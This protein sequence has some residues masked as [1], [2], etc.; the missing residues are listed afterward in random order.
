MPLL[1]CTDIEGGEVILDGEPSTLTLREAI[2]IPREGSDPSW[3]IFDHGGRFVGLAGSFRGP[4]HQAHLTSPITPL[5]HDR[6]GD[7][8]PDARY[9]YGGPLHGHYG[10][11]LLSTL[12]RF[13]PFLDSKD[14]DIKILCHPMADLD[15]LFALPF[16]AE[17]F[18]A[19]GLR[20]ESFVCFDRP[21][22]I[23][24]LVV[25]GAAFEETGFAY[26]VFG[27]LCHRIGDRLT[28]GMP[29]SPGDAPVYMSKARL[30]S[31]VGR[32]VNEEEFSDRLSRAGFD[33]VHPERL[34]LGQQIRLYRDRPQ[35]AALTG[36]S[37][38]TSLFSAGRSIVG[39]SYVNTLYTSYS[40]IDL[41]GGG[42]G[43][44]V[45]PH[46]DIALLPRTRNFHLEYRLTDVAATAEQFIRLCERERRVREPGRNIA[47]G[48]ATRQSSYG[49]FEGLPPVDGRRPSAT[50]GRLTG[51]YQ[52]HT[53]HEEQPW[54]EVDLGCPCSVDAVTL[55][56]RADNSQARMALFTIQ[57]SSDGFAFEDI[58]RQ[59]QPAAFGNGLQDQQL[60][61][62]IAPA[63]TCRYLRVTLPGREFLHLD[64]V[65]IEGTRLPARPDDPGLIAASQTTETTRRPGWFG[66]FF[67]TPTEVR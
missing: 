38:H 41:L 9:V 56:N 13:W 48:C 26:R 20:R 44:Y 12:S 50:N 8:A 6:I 52:F 29:A 5:R 54:W 62:V 27:R 66:R 7:R 58:H 22:L 61:I 23:P 45:Y 18:N 21:T 46:G 51:R 2:Y 36:S 37:L 43:M 30:P 1:S 24:E 40:L 3:G 4:G 10:H 47:L 57:I 14:P 15:D 55:H 19:L 25:P 60:R 39:L 34:P 42:R 28:E 64:Q 65:E 63:V 16:V 11:F 17:I 32:I 67:G 53:H 31:G 49:P 35:I 59:E 33:I